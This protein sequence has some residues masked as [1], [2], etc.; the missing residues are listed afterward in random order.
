MK[1]KILPLVPDSCFVIFSNPSVMVRGKRGCS[2]LSSQRGLYS[3]LD[4]LRT[5]LA[6][7]PGYIEKNNIKIV[8]AIFNYR[9]TAQ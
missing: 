1:K 9:N 8:R 3:Y 7:K 6:L 4:I 2:R 5:D